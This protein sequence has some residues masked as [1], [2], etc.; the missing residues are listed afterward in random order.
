MSK[1]YFTIE[2]KQH[3]IQLHVRGFNKSFIAKNM[4]RGRTSISIL[5]NQWER[6]IIMSNKHTRKRTM[7]LTAQQVYKV[8]D[9]FINNPFNTHAQCI[10]ELELPVVRSTIHNVLKRNGI[11]GYVACF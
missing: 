5:I 10:Q 2:E 8:L 1:R 6:G 7:K 4:N 9:Y 11:R 3:A